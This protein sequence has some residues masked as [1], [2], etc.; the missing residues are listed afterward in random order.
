[1]SRANRQRRNYVDADGAIVT[2]SSDVYIA[3]QEA[4]DRRFCPTCRCEQAQSFIIDVDS[5]GA[6]VVVMHCAPCEVTW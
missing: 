6:L 5:D 2:W 3:R 1:M 4:W